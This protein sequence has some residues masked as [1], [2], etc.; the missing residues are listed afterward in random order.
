[1]QAIRNPVHPDTHTQYATGAGIE[2]YDSYVVIHRALRALMVDT[3][4]RLGRLDTDDDDE[5]RLA[6]EQVRQAIA[7][8]HAHLAKEDAF[9]HPAM[10]ARAPGST[11]QTA[12]DHVSHTAA[13]ERI[14]AA[15]DDVESTRG[16]GRGA[17]AACLYR[18]FALLVADDLLHMDREE[19]ENNAVLWATHTDAE[20]LGLV[21]RLVASIPPEVLARYLPWM[22]AANP[23]RERLK[24]LA[25]VRARLPA[26]GFAKLL[27][28]VL[29]RLSESERGKLLRALA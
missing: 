1:M 2:R 28:S 22:I 14:L 11:H 9:V 24:L 13:F 16:S 19:T 4:V 25:D 15:C 7:L 29:P 12:A 21:A 5:V 27:E 6:L 18:R 17:A 26:Q 10:E 8:G 20:L 3:L 23:P